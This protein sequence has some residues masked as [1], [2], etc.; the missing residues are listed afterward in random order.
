MITSNYI[1]SR[2]FYLFNLLFVAEH[3]LRHDSF[4][5]LTKI[6]HPLCHHPS[7]VPL[8]VLDVHL[9]TLMCEQ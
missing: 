7:G 5:K 9:D 3:P 6:S 1:N 2:Q 8:S 4:E